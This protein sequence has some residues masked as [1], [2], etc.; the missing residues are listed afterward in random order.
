MSSTKLNTRT[1]LVEFHI[2]RNLRSV[3]QEPGTILRFDIDN[4]LHIIPHFDT[5]LEGK[6][7]FVI[8]EPDGSFTKHFVCE[9]K[10]CKII[11]EMS[12]IKGNVE[13][14]LIKTDNEDIDVEEYIKSYPSSIIEQYTIVYDIDE[15]L[16]ITGK[17][18]GNIYLNPFTVSILGYTSGFVQQN[19]MRPVNAYFFQNGQREDIPISQTNFDAVLLRKIKQLVE[20]VRKDPLNAVKQTYFVV[21]LA[22]EPYRS[23]ENIDRSVVKKGMEFLLVIGVNS[24][25]VEE[26]IEIFTNIL[27]LV[28]SELLASKQIPSRIND[29]MNSFSQGVTLGSKSAGEKIYELKDETGVIRQGDI[30]VFFDKSEI[31]LYALTYNPSILFK[32]TESSALE[33][34]IFQTVGSSNL[35]PLFLDQGIFTKVYNREGKLMLDTTETTKNI[36]KENLEVLEAFINKNNLYKEVY[37]KINQIPSEGWE[38]FVS[39][40]TDNDNKEFLASLTQLLKYYTTIGFSLLLQ[41]PRERE[42]A[43]DFL[44]RLVKYSRDKKPENVYLPVPYATNKK[45]EIAVFSLFG[46]LLRLRQKQSSTNYVYL[47]NKK[48]YEKIFPIVYEMVKDKQLAILASSILSSYRIVARSPYGNNL[49]TIFTNPAEVPFE[50]PFEITVG[51]NN[52]LKINGNVIKTKKELLKAV[53]KINNLLQSKLYIM[54]EFPSYKGHTIQLNIYLPEGVKV[55]LQPDRPDQ[56]L[57]SIKDQITQTG[58]NRRF[59]LALDKIKSEGKR[60]IHLPK[61]E[62]Q[63]KQLSDRTIISLLYPFESNIKPYLVPAYPPHVLLAGTPRIEGLPST[64]IEEDRDLRVTSYSYGLL[65]VNTSEKPEEVV[66]KAPSHEDVKIL[67]DQGALLV[68][69]NGSISLI[70][71]TMTQF[72]IFIITYQFNNKFISDLEDILS[73]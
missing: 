67:L 31:L 51:S 39:F 60:M 69:H 55:E 20:T 38:Y 70:A 7:L 30:M 53:S 26:R 73:S 71:D 63:N 45:S 52:T 58:L 41:K 59:A 14:Y 11:N 65:L 29:I 12:I 48:V 13:G 44:D 36:I 21:H 56:S 49:C 43:S 68:T 16:I 62:Q 8:K 46:F 18:I 19:I 6:Y 61:S 3:S 1:K 72:S 17:K 27:P 25:N 34:I 2:N 22:F 66:L 24:E 42:Y 9:N 33:N 64:Y 23:D 15:K 32:F 28:R 57:A 35:V 50:L 47:S 5:S 4:R 54:N 40:L 37:T 10:N